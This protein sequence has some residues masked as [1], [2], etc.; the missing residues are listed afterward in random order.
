MPARKNPLSA[1]GLQCTTQKYV[2]GMTLDD[3][4]RET[5]LSRIYISK[6]INGGDVSDDAVEAIS[7][8]LKVDPKLSR[9]RP[10][11]ERTAG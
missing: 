10:R 4:S 2:L 9:L 11:P 5:N 8:V 6:A 1:W 7:K 3:I